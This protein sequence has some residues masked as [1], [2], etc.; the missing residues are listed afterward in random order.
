MKH[1][2]LALS[3]GAALV[4]GLPGRPA[5]LPDSDL[6]SAL[7]QA[8]RQERLALAT[9]EAVIERF[10]PVRPFAKIVEAER[11]H[12]AAVE[13]LMAA[14]G[15]PPTSDPP[16]VALGT[17]L[18]DCRARAA[19][20]E[21]EAAALY[22]RL[23]RLDLPDDVRAVFENFEE[24]SGEVHRAAFEGGRGPLPPRRGCGDHGAGRPNCDGTG[25]RR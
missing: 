13:K 2:I 5:E 15:V 25:P 20:L 10:G 23:L 17:S 1:L 6:A 21:A 4:P 11:R 3:I 18:R 19:R 22:A 16:D 14:Y 7:R 12:V 9:Y 24:I 8:H